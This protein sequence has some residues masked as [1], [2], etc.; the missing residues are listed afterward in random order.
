[1]FINFKKIDEK[2]VFR[3]RSEFA[4][5]HELSF[6]GS[7]FGRILDLIL[8]NS[9]VIYLDIDLDLKNY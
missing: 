2:K 8:G 3:I 9:K 1:M 6:V 5:E 4:G 7:I